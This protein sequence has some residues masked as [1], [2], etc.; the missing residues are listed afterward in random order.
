[1]SNAPTKC[2]LK[3]C[4][5]DYDAA[6]EMMDTIQGVVDEPTEEALARRYSQRT[7]HGT[8]FFIV[9]ANGGYAASRMVSE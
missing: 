6:C 2:V 9:H 3:S 4:W 8:F 5:D 7:S 1:M